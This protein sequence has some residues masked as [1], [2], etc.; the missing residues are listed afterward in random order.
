[1]PASDTRAAGLAKAG[2]YVRIVVSLGCRW[3]RVARLVDTDFAAAGQRDVREEA[4]PLVLH[5]IAL[6]GMGLHARD[7]RRDV[8]AHQVELVDV[9]LLGWMDGDLRRRQSEDE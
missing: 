2:P 9:V 5:R 6:D 8:V 3:P 4:P 1:M 7:E